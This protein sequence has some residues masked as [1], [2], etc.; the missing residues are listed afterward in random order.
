MIQPNPKLNPNPLWHEAQQGGST[1]NSQLF[2]R[3]LHVLSRCVYA[4]T[5]H[6]PKIWKVH[7]NGD[8]RCTSLSRM[9]YLNVIAKYLYTNGPQIVL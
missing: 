7:W 4:V 2:G 6:H 1:L 5:S 9:K 8:R 3:S